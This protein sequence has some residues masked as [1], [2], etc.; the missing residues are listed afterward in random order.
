MDGMDRNP[1]ES[2]QSVS[3][4][5]E[6]PKNLPQRGDGCLGVLALLWILPIL[7]DTID[8]FARARPVTTSNV[9]AI[10]ATSVVGVALILWIAWRTL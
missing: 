1:H 8:L 4:F 6:Q 10:V 9:L 5:E 3:E 2:P 7:F